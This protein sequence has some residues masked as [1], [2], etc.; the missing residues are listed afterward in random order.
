MSVFRDE[1]RVFLEIIFAA[2]CI[3]GVSAWICALILLVIIPFNTIGK[4]NKLMIRLNPL[5]YVF[6][7]SELTPKGLKIRR[8]FFISIAIFLL[9]ILLSAGS[10]L[11]MQ[12]VN[13]L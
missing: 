7:S 2:G 9:S 6:Y 12:L 11:I 4:S 3:F 13:T 10:G 5:N 1:I 8:Y